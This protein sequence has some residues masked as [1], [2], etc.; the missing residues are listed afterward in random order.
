M[1]DNPK[2]AEE[3]MAKAIFISADCWL[4]VF[5]LLPPRQLGL[6]IALISHRFDYYVDEHFKTR[7][8]TLGFIRIWSKIG[9]NGTKEM[10]IIKSYHGKPLPIPQIPMP[11]KVTGFKWI[12]INFI[13]QNVIAFL[14][15]F[16][17]IFDSF[18]PINL[19]IDMH[20]DRITEFFLRNIWPMIV[21]NIHGLR[22]PVRFFNNLRKFVP[23]IL[24][25]CPSL[26][27]FLFNRFSCD[28][29]PEFPC[30]DS[31]A[32]SDGQAL[33]KWLFTARPDNLPKVFKCYFVMNEWKNWLFKIAAVE[34]AFASASSPANFIVVFWFN[35]SRAGPVQTFYS[36]KEYT[37]EQL[38]LKRADQSDHFLL[39]C[40]PIARDESKWTK[41]ENEAIDW[42]ICDQ[43]NQIHIQIFGEYEIG[44]G[45]LDATPGPSDQQK[46]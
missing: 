40:S 42:E 18:C 27:F 4:C 11:R 21:K 45:L 28:L 43:W 8:W 2:E 6:G 23:S 14:R 20:N 13:D 25:D 41:W 34:A 38:V 9:E 33:A 1:S 24:N 29:F 31:A 36:T 12:T 5:D 26:R 46:K 7:K 3:K 16:R 44:K 17:P 22:L 35:L 10:E 32:A 30:D 39:V 19:T 15:R 37:R